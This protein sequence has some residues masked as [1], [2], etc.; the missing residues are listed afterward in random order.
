V[1]IPFK[2]GI[3]HLAGSKE[4]TDYLVGSKCSACGAMA[5]PARVICHKCSSDNVNEIALSKTGKLVV[6]T[7]AW[8]APE[9]VKPPIIQGYVDLPEGVRVFTM[10]TG[11]ETS[12]TALKVGQEME[13]VFE[14]IRTDSDGNRVVAFKFKPAGKGGA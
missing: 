4:D 1:I 11:V 14:E 8:T 9:G 10:I 12:K 7:V 13:L 6:F 2:N 5:F 3:M